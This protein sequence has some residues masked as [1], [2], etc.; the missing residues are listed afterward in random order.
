LLRSHNGTPFLTLQA[1]AS[2]TETQFLVDM[3]A[4]A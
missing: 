3:V 4:Y 1:V 2:A